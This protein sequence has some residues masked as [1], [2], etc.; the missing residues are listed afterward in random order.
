MYLS[1]DFITKSDKMSPNQI[2]TTSTK[3]IRISNETYEYLANQGT[4]HDSFDS[5]IRKLIQ[6]QQMEAIHKN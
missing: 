4:L 3:Q 5:V 1:A 2:T 6:R